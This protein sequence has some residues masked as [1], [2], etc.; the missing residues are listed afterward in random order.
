LGEALAENV[1]TAINNVDKDNDFI[2]FPII[3]GGKR[4]SIV[5]NQLT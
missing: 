2:N 5:I 3:Y 4:P 1:V